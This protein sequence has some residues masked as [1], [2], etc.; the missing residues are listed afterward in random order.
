VVGPVFRTCLCGLDAKPNRPRFQL[1]GFSRVVLVSPKRIFSR[2]WVNEN[3]LC[4]Y[5]NKTLRDFRRDEY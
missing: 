2:N 5:L 3:L 1:S 4:R